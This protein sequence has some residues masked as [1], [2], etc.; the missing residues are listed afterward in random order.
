MSI[1]NHHFNNQ[2]V[3]NNSSDLETISD[4]DIMSAF[5]LDSEPED[6]TK[7]IDTNQS[8]NLD[9]FD[10][11]QYNSDSPIELLQE[12]QQAPSKGEKT[13]KRKAVDTNGQPS[14]KK[15]CHSSVLAA[16][17]QSIFRS[18]ARK[19][20]NQ[21]ENDASI[22]SNEASISSP[23]NSV[24]DQNQNYKKCESFLNAEQKSNLQEQCDDNFLNEDGSSNDDSQSNFSFP[25]NG[26]NSRHCS[27]D[28][29]KTS[30]KNC[31][32]N[33]HQFA[34][35]HQRHSRKK[36]NCC[37][38]KWN[39]H[40]SRRRDN[41]SPLNSPNCYSSRCCNGGHCDSAPSSSMPSYMMVSPDD[42]S[43]LIKNNV[44]KNNGS[45]AP[46]V[47]M[48]SET[49]STDGDPLKVQLV[50]L[51]YPMDGKNFYEYV[52]SILFH[53]LTTHNYLVSTPF[54]QGTEAKAFYL[55]E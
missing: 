43:S 25:C 49:D 34:K 52:G 27:C 41:K 47:M 53:K 15:S 32:N 14:K 3:Q 5:G 35:A 29:E 9:N 16:L 10:Y 21:L 1:P 4:I 18:K 37:S 33:N 30:C 46:F 50:Y 39:H 19:I 31:H 23:N 17:R 26:N 11:S 12:N 44:N 45:N 36:H 24:V 20:V 38:P 22:C 42:L 48:P 51:V 6:S 2:A 13:K 54:L 40:C 7:L 55:Q 8:L 28:E